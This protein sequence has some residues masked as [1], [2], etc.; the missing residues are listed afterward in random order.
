MLEQASDL[1]DQASNGA[2]AAVEDF[3]KDSLEQ[4]E[5]LYDEVAK[6]HE[7]SQY[8]HYFDKD[9]DNC[10]DDDDDDEAED[11]KDDAEDWKDWAEEWFGWDYFGEDEADYEDGDYDEYFDKDLMKAFEDFYN[12]IDA[13]IDAQLFL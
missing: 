7:N 12:D 2:P 8:S 3:V 5:D 9:D 10:E 4:L 13:Q 6:Y 11:D 1:L